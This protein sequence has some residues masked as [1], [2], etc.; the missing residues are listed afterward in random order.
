MQILPRRTVHSRGVT[1]SLQSDNPITYFRWS[2]Y[3]TK[4]PET[5]DWIDSCVREN[6]VFFDIGAN[7]GVYSLYVAQR[8]ANC[9]V[10]AFEPEFANLHLLRDNVTSN[11]LEER[12]SVFSLALSDRVGIS[13]LHVQ[14][15]T[16]GSAM[17]TESP[18]QLDSTIG[19]QPVIV[20]EG[21][22]TFTLDQFCSETKISPH[23]LKIDVDGTESKILAGSQKT[24]QSPTL[25]SILIECSETKDTQVQCEKLLHG[26]GFRRTWHDSKGQ[27]ENQIWERV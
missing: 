7:I 5:L 6:D 9:K 24:L 19:Q 18:Q 1:F 27:S 4:E 12:I 22:C 13:Y 16:P 8:H 21:L 17:H 3:N 10:V 23:C 11:H 26:S 25:R 20:H 14:D 15:L 2:S